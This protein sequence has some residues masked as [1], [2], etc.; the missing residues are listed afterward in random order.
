MRYRPG[1]PEEQQAMRRIR[2]VI[3]RRDPEAA[4]R[5][6]PTIDCAVDVVPANAVLTAH[7]EGCLATGFIG[8]QYE[9]LAR[10]CAAHDIDGM[11]LAIHRD[12]KA[13]ELLAGLIDGS[14]VRL[15]PAYRG[16]SRYELFRCFRSRCSIPPSAKCARRSVERASMRS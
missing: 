1:V 3:A 6:L 13:R 4:S 15:D 2:E 5:L 14:R 8:G 11:E 10:Y 12:D 9:W 7:Y 16:D